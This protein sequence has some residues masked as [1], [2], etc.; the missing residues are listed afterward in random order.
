MPWVIPPWL[1]LVKF[2]GLTDKEYGKHDNDEATM[3]AMTATAATA[4][5][6]TPTTGMAVIMATTTKVTWM[7][8]VAAT[9]TTT[10][11]MSTTTTMTM[12]Q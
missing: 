11:V 10:T 12:G 7:G 3:L 5:A 6:A 8:M 4:M 2:L 9:T 1:A